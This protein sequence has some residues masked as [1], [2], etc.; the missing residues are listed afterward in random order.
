[1]GVRRQRAMSLPEQRVD[2]RTLGA[3]ELAEHGQTA[4]PLTQPPPRL[5]QPVMVR[6]AYRGQQINPFAGLAQNPDR[7]AAPFV[8]D[9]PPTSSRCSA[10]FLFISQDY[11][12]LIARRT[13]CQC[14]EDAPHCNFVMPPPA[15]A[16]VV[17]GI[18]G[19]RPVPMPYAQTRRADSPTRNPQYDRNSHPLHPGMAKRRHPGGAQGNGGAMRLSQSPGR[20]DIARRRSRWTHGR[21]TCAGRT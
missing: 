4:S 19:W 2:Q 16:Q 8:G 9:A 7:L 14:S 18:P 13:G 1:M 10:M 6:C 21:G 5:V 12:H 15:G 20:S 11:L 3:F 17:A